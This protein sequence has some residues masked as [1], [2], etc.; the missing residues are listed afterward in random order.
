M[1]P[2]KHVDISLNFMPA[3]FVRHAGISYGE[4]YYFDPEYRAHV[5]CAE[6]KFLFDVFGEYG[7][8]RPSPS[9]S[10]DLFIQP[11]DLIKL[12]QGATLVCPQ[13]ATLESRGHPWATLSPRE[14]MCLDTNSV[15]EHPFIKRVLAQY[16]QMTHLYGAS[17]D[18]FGIKSGWLNMHTPFTTAHQLCGEQLFYLLIDDPESASMILAKIWDMYQA[19]TRVLCAI[20][21]APFPRRVSMGD[22]SASLLS[23]A[24]YRDVILPTNAAIARG[25][26]MVGYHSCGPSTHLLSAFRQLPRVD[27]L[28]IGP[29][30]DLAA[31]SRLFPD[32]HLRPLIDPVMMREE[33]AAGVEA[34]ISSLLDATHDVRVITLCAWSFDRE[35]PFDN[36]RAMYHTMQQA[37]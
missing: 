18:L 17:A 12:T 14:I 36:V 16:R 21:D 2:T 32:V 15:T 13:D 9:P 7:I 29:G 28:E 34:Q 35:T 22:C 3:F 6:A 23:P 5:E 10:P 20:I 31:T 1:N 11:I 8:G 27:T 33:T 4:A 19:L 26:A 25:F 24:Q 30:T 37:R